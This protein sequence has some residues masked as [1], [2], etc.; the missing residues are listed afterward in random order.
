VSL[1][2]L[3][4][5]VINYWL[6]PHELLHTVDLDDPMIERIL[7]MMNLNMGRYDIAEFI[8]QHSGYADAHEPR[9]G[10]GRLYRASPF[11]TMPTLVFPI[12]G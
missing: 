6:V 8:R 10:D 4:Q 12:P 11:A 2:D 1:K 7:M 3:S 5:D 9:I